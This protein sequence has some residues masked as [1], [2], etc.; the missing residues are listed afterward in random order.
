MQRG[1]A[2]LRL[3][4]SAMRGGSSGFP[5]TSPEWPKKEIRKLLSRRTAG[6]FQQESLARKQTKRAELVVGRAAL[7]HHRQ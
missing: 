6:V 3:P 7:S 5:T 1:N 4:P 2:E